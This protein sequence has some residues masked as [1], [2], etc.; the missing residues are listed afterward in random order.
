MS[1]VLAAILRRKREE[2]RER[3]ARQPEA[4]LL[5]RVRDEAPARGFRL[6]LAAKIDAGQPAVIAEFKR[7]SP[8]KGWIAEDADPAV[9]ALAY[10]QAGAA[11][12][13]VLTDIDHFG[14]ADEHLQQARAACALPAIRK[15]FNID[16]YQLI[17]ARSL[18]ADAILLIVAALSPSQLAELQQ[19]ATELGLD[20]LVEVHDAKELD[21]ALA[22]G[23]GL[24]GI[25]NRNLRTFDTRL[26]TTLELLPRVPADRLLVTESG[27]HTAADVATMRN[28][29]V[30]AF[31]VGES[32]MRGGR[33]G[34]AYAVLFGSTNGDL[35]PQ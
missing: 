14:G 20:V 7:R 15:D 33:P 18:G 25:N 21:I 22:A 26:E 6:A 1:D 27:I 2:V 8:S 4:R 31:L 13:S 30:H 24:V 23:A 34:D 12:L 17:E 5:A 16:P 11:C 28:A 10:A 3:R 35:R 29:G 32:L 9:V 19:C